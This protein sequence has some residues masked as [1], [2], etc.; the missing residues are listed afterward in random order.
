MIQAALEC[1][2]T[3]ADAGWGTVLLT[4]VLCGAS[5]ASLAAVVIHRALPHRLYAEDDS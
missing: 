2:N 3:V 5:I 1:T 4:M